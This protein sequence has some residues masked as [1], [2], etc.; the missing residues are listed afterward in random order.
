VGIMKISDLKLE[1]LQFFAKKE[2]LTHTNRS[3]QLKLIE[4]ISKNVGSLEIHGEDRNYNH[5]IQLFIH[6]N[7]DGQFVPIEFHSDDTLNHLVKSKKPIYKAIVR[8]SDIGPYLVDYWNVLDLIN[9]EIDTDYVTNDNVPLLIM[10]ELN[11]ILDPFTDTQEFLRFSLP[12]RNEKYNWINELS[13]YEELSDSFSLE[14]LVFGGFEIY[15][16]MGI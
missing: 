10:S 8:I 5:D 16:K 3:Y 9:G 13:E 6:F 1:V 11:K 2:Y 7:H 14:E 12:E 4:S 15:S